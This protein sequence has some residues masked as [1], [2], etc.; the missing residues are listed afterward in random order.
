MSKPIAIAASLLLTLV[1]LALVPTASGQRFGGVGTAQGDILRGQGA[2][3]AGAGWYNLNTA[4]ANNINVDTWKKYNLEVQRLYQVWLRDRATHIQYKRKLTAGVQEDLARKAEEAQRRWRENP[5]P[6]DIT[7][8]DA[9]NALAMDLADPSVEPTSWRSAPVPLPPELSLTS[10]S[11]KVAD[12]KTSSLLQSTVAIDRLLLTDGWPIWLRRPELRKEEE[13]YRKAVT[14]V[15]EKCRNGTPLEAGDVDRLRETVVD[16]QKKVPEVVP[17]RDS[18]R[19]NAIEFIKLLD[20][21]TRIFAEQTYAER[22]IKDVTEHKAETV[23]ELLGFMRYHRLLFAETNRSPESA[24]RYEALYQ[25]LREQKGKLGISGAP[26]GLA[27]ATVTPANVPSAAGYWRT[28][29]GPVFH[30][31]RDGKIIA[32]NNG[33]EIGNWSQDGL[34]L[35]VRFTGPNAAKGARVSNVTLSP[36]G[37]SY[38]GT[39]ARGGPVS[40][41][42]LE[43]PPQ[44]PAAKKKRRG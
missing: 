15:V 31:R 34:S 18:Q 44:G 8:G 22:L 16:L 32:V 1:T 28:Q 27:A 7:S 42:R 30:L 11:F 36:D 29:Q 10:L 20:G 14:T 35:T 38:E 24:Q 21:A 26:G 13:A 3:L 6:D 41:Q 2:Y 33:N 5:S 9:L 37:R 25:L 43:G 4:R 12:K 17:G 39:N 19:A 23:A 40:G